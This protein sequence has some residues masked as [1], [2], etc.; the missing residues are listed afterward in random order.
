MDG[1]PQRIHTDQKSYER[2]KAKKA[3]GLGAKNDGAL[4]AKNAGR[5][6]FLTHSR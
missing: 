5:L 3:S 1:S 2:K 4:G 6:G